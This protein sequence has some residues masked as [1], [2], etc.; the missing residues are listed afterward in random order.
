[1]Q[2]RDHILNFLRR[3]LAAE[4]R[5]HIA[6]PDY[7]LDYMFIRGSQSTGKVWLFEDAFEARSLVAMGGIRRMA[8]QA[9]DVI[10]AAPLS[11][12][13]VQAEFSIRHLLRI[14]P[15]AAQQHDYHQREKSE[16][17][18]LQHQMTIMSVAQGFANLC[19][20]VSRRHAN[21]DQARL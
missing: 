5:H 1:M 4:S 11:L 2:V 10:G 8:A 19:S 20:L 21:Q 12:L 18:R 7:G 17:G 9:V 14:L 3:H 16:C 15:T 6:A 13:R